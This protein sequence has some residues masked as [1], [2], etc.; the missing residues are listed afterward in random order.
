MLLST[1]IEL[2]KCWIDSTIH[3]CAIVDSVIHL[4]IWVQTSCLNINNKNY[5]MYIIR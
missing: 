5:C 2:L 4:N 1:R 3:N